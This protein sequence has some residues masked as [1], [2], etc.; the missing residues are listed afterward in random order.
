[1]GEAIVL[2]ERRVALDDRGVPL[3]ERRSQPGLQGINV[4]RGLISWKRSRLQENQICSWLGR[5]I[6]RFAQASRRRLRRKNVARVKARPVQSIDERGQLRGRQT[7]H[8]VADRRPAKRPFLKALPIQNQAGAVPGQNL[9]P[10]RPLRAKDEDRPRERIAL[11]LVLR[12]RRQA[13]GAASEVDRLRRHKNPNAR[14][15]PNHVAAFTAR[16]TF[17]SAATSVPGLTRTTAAPS[18]ISIVPH[19]ITQEAAEDGVAAATITGAKVTLPE[20]SPSHGQPAVAH[21]DASRT[22][23]PASDHVAP[24]QPRLCPRS[25]SSLRESPP[26]APASKRASDPIP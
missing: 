8:S 6:S 20:A 13:V 2:P 7:H 5:E 4:E 19:G 12:Q 11:K 21:R 1:M 22:A 3:R 26:F 25:H 18:A 17:V 23:A 14:G 15:N 16:S 24:R 9:Q 10:V